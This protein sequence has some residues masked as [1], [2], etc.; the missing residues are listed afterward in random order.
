MELSDSELAGVKSFREYIELMEKKEEQLRKDCEIK[1]KGT[2]GEQEI[3]E[4]REG[5]RSFCSL[6]SP[7]PVA[8]G[9]KFLTPNFLPMNECTNKASS[10][11]SPRPAPWRSYWPVIC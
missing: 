4:H 6:H 7:S 5:S 1:D 9:K 8:A 3:E 11:R 10:D 2:Y